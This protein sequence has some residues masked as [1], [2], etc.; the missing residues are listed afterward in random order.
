MALGDGRSPAAAR[1]VLS[2]QRKTDTRP[3]ADK[4]AAV[5]VSRVGSD[6]GRQ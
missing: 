3:S 5:V 6:G 1:I 4:A 2:V